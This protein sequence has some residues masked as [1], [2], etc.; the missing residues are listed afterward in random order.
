MTG[1]RQ[2]PASNSNRS[3]F[4]WNAQRPLPPIDGPT[5]LPVIGDSPSDTILS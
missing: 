2:V 3:R 1:D 4:D 5:F